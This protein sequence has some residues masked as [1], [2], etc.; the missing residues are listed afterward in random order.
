M[1]HF[2]FAN[3]PIDLHSLRCSARRLSNR[4]FKAEDHS[5]LGKRKASTPTRAF[6]FEI[7]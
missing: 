1:S 3:R 6:V 2:V 7:T 4:G 5:N